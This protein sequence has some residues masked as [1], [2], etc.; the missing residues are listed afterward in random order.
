ML[1]HQGVFAN[2][3]LLIPAV[4]YCADDVSLHVAPMFHVAD[5]CAS[6]A[7]LMAGGR[8]AFVPRFEPEVVLG[9]VERH[10][11]TN[12]ILIPA[13]IQTLIHHPAIG[14]YDLS[15]WRLLF[16]GGAPIADEML[17]R[18][19]EVLPCGLAQGYGQTEA[20]HTI[21]ILTEDDHRRALEDPRLLRS[22]GRP[23]PGV[24]VR[25]TGDDGAP[26]PAGEI[27][28]IVVRASHVM[29]GYWNRPEETADAL[30]GGWLHTGDL[31]TLDGDGY[32]ALVDRKKDMI[33]SGG[34]N[35]YS[36]EVE[37]ALAG[38]AGVAEVAVIAVPDEA[39]GEHVHAVIVPATDAKPDEDALRDHCRRTIAGYK[40]PRSFE[41]V[42]ALPRTAA[43]KVRK[44]ILREP[45]WRDRDRRVS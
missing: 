5:F 43:G 34:E 39:L 41:F 27:G 29:K 16:Y 14:D 1:T 12:M 40:V 4:G 23:L 25:V 20:T 45:H 31:G 21:S 36:A 11:V 18:C 13:M 19:F 44:E 17:A 24:H 6:F 42:D 28:E 35:V 15:S 9:A 2:A 22:C 32:L 30:R 8:H 10:R 26:V 38:H 3:A 7:Q 37:N 33:V